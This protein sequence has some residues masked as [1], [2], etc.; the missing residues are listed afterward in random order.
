MHVR[1][2]HWDAFYQYDQCLSIFVKKNSFA[3]SSTYSRHNQHLGALKDEVK[4]RKLEL[5]FPPTRRPVQSQRSPSRLPVAGQKQG[6]PAPR[7]QLQSRGCQRLGFPAHLPS[8]GPEQQSEVVA[9]VQL[10]LLPGGRGHFED[11]VGRC[12]DEP[13]PGAGPLFV[14]HPH[15]VPGQAQET[16]VRTARSRHVYQYPIEFNFAFV[17]CVSLLTRIFRAVQRKGLDWP[18][19][20]LWM[21]PE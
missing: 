6:H 15:P 8:A 1:D 19:K 12:A 5:G 4:G 7:R 18:T 10:D 17:K 3:V 11:A 2:E 20:K 13:L 14:P 9:H 16:L 21:N